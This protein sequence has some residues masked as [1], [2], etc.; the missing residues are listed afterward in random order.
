MH[1]VGWRVRLGDQ[2]RELADL[3][4]D[5]EARPVVDAARDDRQA[6]GVAVLLERRGLG[7]RQL[8]L[9]RQRPR[10]PCELLLRR[11]V[12]AHLRED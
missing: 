6:D 12:V 7:E 4:R 1:Q 9:R 8:D 2:A 3:E 11:R 5:L 10:Y